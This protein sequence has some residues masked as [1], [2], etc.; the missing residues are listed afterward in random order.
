MNRR[1]FF[2]SLGGLAALGA[3]PPIASSQENGP[4][5]TTLTHGDGKAI[6]KVARFDIPHSWKRLGLLLQRTIEGPGSSVI[7]DPCIVRDE[8]INGWRMFLFF[9]PPGCGQAVCPQGLDPG[10]GHWRLYEHH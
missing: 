9:D 5:Q 7:G 6:A 1:D 8:D 2:G 3:M 4:H 10:A